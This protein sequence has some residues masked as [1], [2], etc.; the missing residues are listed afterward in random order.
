[1]N[2]AP[3]ASAALFLTSSLAFADTGVTPDEQARI[4]K[5][6]S[7]TPLIDGH[8]DIAE[9]IKE[10][11]DGDPSRVDLTKDT[12]SLPLSLHTDIARLRQGMVGAQFWSVY[13]PAE[14]QGATSAEAVHVQIDIV[15][16]IVARY[17]D[18]FE[19]AQ[20][21]DEIE[22]I[23]KAG[24]IA[25]MFGMEGGEAINNNLAILRDFRAEGVLYMTLCHGKTTS[26]VDSATDAPL[27]GG[28]SAFGETV[29]K[30][31]NRIG[32]LVDL[33]HT[34]ADAMKDALKVTKAPVIFSHSSAMALNGHP[35][36]V[37]DDVLKLVAKNGG[38]VMAN[39]VPPFIAEDVRQWMANQAAEEARQKSLFPG[40][41]DAAKAAL[42]AWNAANPRPDATI[43]DV[44]DH[45]EHIRDVA[46]IDNVGIGSDFDGIPYTPV[47]LEGVETY[48]AL[49]AELM[50]RGW[51]DEDLAK[52]AGGN[53]LRALRVA[54]RVAAKK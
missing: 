12:R 45:I 5:I 53:L 21:A 23:F 42:D 54:E 7:A 4:E 34:S 14:L 31:M 44:A 22:R 39:F 20:T 24:R 35:R 30:E 47:G 52:L 17:P 43:A 26:W 29:I 50:R 49:F 1:M 32:M 3:I 15:R 2:L 28:L 25:S 6:L 33:S 9:Q 8:N 10:K 40:D 13:V 41:P 36:N 48:P 46:S 27:H 11:Y 18:V 38:V 37:P 19:L 16:Q 51:S